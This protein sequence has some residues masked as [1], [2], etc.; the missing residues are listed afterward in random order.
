MMVATLKNWSDSIRAQTCTVIEGRS[1][2][3]LRRGQLCLKHVDGRF[4]VIAEG[5]LWQGVLRVVERG[6]GEVFGFAD[7]NALVAAGWVLD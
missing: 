1:P 6:T 7:A 3:A 4:G 5:D 2:V